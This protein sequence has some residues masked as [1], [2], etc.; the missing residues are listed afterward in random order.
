VHLRGGNGKPLIASYSIGLGTVVVDNISMEMPWH[1]FGAE[2]WANDLVVVEN[3]VRFALYVQPVPPV[4]VVPANAVLEAESSDGTVYE[5]EATSTSAVTCEPVSGSAFAL[6]LT[7]VNCSATNEDGTTTESFTVTVVDTQGPVISAP[8]AIN[9]Q[10]G[11]TAGGAT[12][13]Y[14]VSALDVVDGAVNVVCDKASGTFLIPQGTSTVT[15]T[16]ADLSDN[17]STATFDVEVIDTDGPAVYM[18]ATAPLEQEG[19]TAGGA[20]FTYT[21]TAA[22]VV[23]GMAT[24][25]TCDHAS[26]SV[27]PVGTTTVSCS[28]KDS[29]DRETIATIDVVVTDTT[30]PVITVPTVA[31]QEA[32]AAGGATV[33]YTVS[34][35]DV[36][37]GSQTVTCDKPSD[38]LFPL[39][40]NTVTCTST[41]SGNSE[42]TAQCYVVVADTTSPIVTMVAVS[43]LTL[44]SNSAAGGAV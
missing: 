20:V 37:E 38:T 19:D 28:S 12:V 43:S 36:V 14:N 44:V 31:V 30:G 25:V 5:F 8:S 13:S 15:C 16:S 41:D 32:T 42:T 3:L 6:G 18:T 27:F 7:T 2:G 24:D 26:G 35:S 4:V 21:V 40:N 11:N 9:S 34:A 33:T 29:G 1:D 23:D 17:E 39:G 22:D 10:Q